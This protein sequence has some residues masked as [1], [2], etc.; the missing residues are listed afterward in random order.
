MAGAFPQPA[1]PG[2]VSLDA[3][4][5]A[6]DSAALAKAR[7]E[8]QMTETKEAQGAGWRATLTCWL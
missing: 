6:A 3:V 5:S 7:A 1:A 4:V 8:L 2:K